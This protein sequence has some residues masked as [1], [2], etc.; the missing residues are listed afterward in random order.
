[1]TDY[2][3]RERRRLTDT[4]QA[5]RDQHRCVVCGQPVKPLGTSKPLR[6]PFECR[7]CAKMGR[8]CITTWNYGP[9]RASITHESI[10]QMGYSLRD[11]SGPEMG[12]SGDDE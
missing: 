3:S 6:Y 1:M 2:F 5:L 4:E 7:D 12:T 10:R 8:D 9:A 11:G